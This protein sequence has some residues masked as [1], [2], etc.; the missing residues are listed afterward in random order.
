M[1]ALQAGEESET[2]SE[3]GEVQ[4]PQVNSDAIQA[5]EE[6]ETDSEEDDGKGAV[7]PLYLSLFLWCNYQNSC[8]GFPL[9]N[10]QHFLTNC[11][12]TTIRQHSMHNHPKSAC[13][14][15]SGVQTRFS[16]FFFV[17][18]MIHTLLLFLDLFFP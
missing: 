5:G 10:V 11:C 2:D 15:Q 9:C 13:V 17:L 18:I 14:A 7:V 1:S 3:D 12:R 6:S 8:Y 16:S 4:V